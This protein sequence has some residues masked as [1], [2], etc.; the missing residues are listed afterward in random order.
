MEDANVWDVDRIAAAK[1]LASLRETSEADWGQIIAKAFSRSRFQSYQWA[2]SRVH[3]SA[4]KV[5]EAESLEEF[6][7]REAV[8]ADGYRH[9]EECLMSQ[10]PSELLEAVARPPK[11]QG[12]VLRALLRSARQQSVSKPKT[13]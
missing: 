13:S 4:I 3:E 12:Q 10:T 5:L 6:Q 1:L 7:R 9:A 11:S 8:W 2:A